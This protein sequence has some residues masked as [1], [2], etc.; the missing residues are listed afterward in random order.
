MIEEIEVKSLFAKLTVYKL[1]LLVLI[2]G[3]FLLSRYC[4]V[5]YG[6]YCEHVW[7]MINIAWL[8]EP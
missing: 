4:P 2:V 1:V 5:F 8:L 3:C 7:L 6:G